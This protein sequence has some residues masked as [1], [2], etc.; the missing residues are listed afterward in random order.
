MAAIDDRVVALALVGMGIVFLVLL[1]VAG[2]VT[3]LRLLDARWQVAEQT[4]QAADPARK[5][6]IDETTLV[7]IAAA[8]ATV[9]EGRGRIRSIRRLRPSAAQGT[10]WSAQG[11]LVLHTSHTVAHH[12]PGSERRVEGSLR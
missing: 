4:S 2:L 8:V 10:P 6:T 5:T 12:T 9:C 11:R 7:L 1:V 3:L